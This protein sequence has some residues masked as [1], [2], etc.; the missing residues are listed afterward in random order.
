[1]CRHSQEPSPDA[2]SGNS[3][4][5]GGVGVVARQVGTALRQKDKRHRRITRFRG[6]RDE[7]DSHF[8]PCVDAALAAY[9]ARRTRGRKRK[10][11]LALGVL[12]T[13]HGS[14]DHAWVVEKDEEGLWHVVDDTRPQTS[15][16]LILSAF[17]RTGYS[18]LAYVNESEIRPTPAAAGLGGFRPQFFLD[19]HLRIEGSALNG[20]FPA[21]DVAEMNAMNWQA[22]MVGYDPREHGDNATLREALLLAEDRLAWKDGTT[23]LK[24]VV[25]A[26]SNVSYGLAFHTLADFYA[27]SS[28]VPAAAFFFGGLKNVPTFDDACQNADFLAFLKGDHWNNKMLWHAPKGYTVAPY[29]LPPEH[30]QCLISGAYP[31]GSGSMKDGWSGRDGLP[32]HDHFAVDQPGSAPVGANPIVPR[33]HPFAFPYVWTE[34]FDRREALATLHVRN[35][36]TRLQHSHPAPLL[37][38]PVSTL[39]SALFAPEWKVPGK[40]LLS[41][42]APLV[43]DAKRKPAATG[44]ATTKTPAPASRRKSR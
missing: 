16:G 43:R 34:Q 26:P 22:D 42:V 39:S 17:H 36:A 28:Y 3:E 24:T 25:N 4:L 21:S 6:H 27:H 29:A 11:W 38:V 9:A 19:I 14:E 30:Q 8:E 31:E 15:Q 23:P 44:A 12:Q 35:A 10:V 7:S 1:M 32:I 41:N 20:L 18:P 5:S 13:P 33:Q 37:G 40:G 2:V